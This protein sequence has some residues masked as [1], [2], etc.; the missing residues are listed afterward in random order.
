MARPGDSKVKSDLQFAGADL[1]GVE[2]D[3]SQPEIGDASN[4]DDSGGGGFF[5]PGSNGND[6]DDDDFVETRRAPP[7]IPFPS[8]DQVRFKDCYIIMAKIFLTAI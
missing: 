1:D 8:E 2:Y 3:E 5:R 4:D 6:D 7:Q